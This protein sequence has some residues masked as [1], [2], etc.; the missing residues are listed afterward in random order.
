MTALTIRQWRSTSRSDGVQTASGIAPEVS[1]PGMAN[2]IIRAPNDTR[3]LTK[4]LTRAATAGKGPGFLVLGAQNLTP[5]VLLLVL[6]GQ[7]IKP[8]VILAADL[9]TLEHFSSLISDGRVGLML[10]DV[11]VE[12]PL[13]SIVWDHLEAIR[14]SRSYVARASRDLR[15]SCALECM[16]SLA[17]DLGLCTFGPSTEAGT[18]VFPCDRKFDYLPCA[19]SPKSAGLGTLRTTDVSRRS[20]LNA[21]LTR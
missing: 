3:S 13:S 2:E 10:D 6:D 8:R 14:F 21:A 11:N 9:A 17:R 15:T 5:D 12:T 4:A 16:L 1:Q 7:F 20:S 18:E 19:S